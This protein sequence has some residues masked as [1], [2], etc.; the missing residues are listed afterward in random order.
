MELTIIEQNGWKKSVEIK[1]AVIRIGS[2]AANDVQLT[3]PQISPVQLQLHYLQEN[4]STC[5]VLNVGGE[6]VVWQNQSQAVLPPYAL[7]HISNGSEIVLGEYRIQFKL[8]FAA[9]HHNGRRQE[10]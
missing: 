6:V 10:R 2:A 3:S 1:K 9:G 5:K 4:P 8:P 7:T